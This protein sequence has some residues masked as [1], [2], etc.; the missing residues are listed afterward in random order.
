MAKKAK[1]IVRREYTAADVKQLRAHSKAKTPVAKIAKQM[2]RT[3]GSL[4]QKAIKLG[5]PLGHVR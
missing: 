3:E 5:I 4:R 1:K 2:K